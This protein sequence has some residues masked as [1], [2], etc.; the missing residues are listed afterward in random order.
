MKTLSGHR[1]PHSAPIW[2]IISQLKLAWVE[3]I[4]AV[5]S[6]G[7]SDRQVPRSLCSAGGYA[8]EIRAFLFGIDSGSTM[9]VDEFVS[10]SLEGQRNYDRCTAV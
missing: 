8:Q 4:R 3:P 5:K 2:K 10:E 1:P 6:N 9:R 7:A